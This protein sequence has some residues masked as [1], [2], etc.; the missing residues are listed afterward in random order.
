MLIA[1]QKASWALCTVAILAIAGMVVADRLGDIEG[2]SRFVLSKNYHASCAGIAAALLVVV[3][4]CAARSATLGLQSKRQGRLWSRRRKIAYA[5]SH[6]VAW[7][8]AVNFAAWLAAALA[9]AASADAYCRGGAAVAVAL[10]CYFTAQNTLLLIFCTEGHM[11]TFML[12]HRSDDIMVL[13]QPLRV[14]W[15]KL[16]LWLAIEGALCAAVITSYTHCS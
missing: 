9:H 1:V 14:H 16:V 11:M 7:V 4:A 2:Q 10:F 5:R 3:V 6:A 12:E 8:T 13:D 15:P